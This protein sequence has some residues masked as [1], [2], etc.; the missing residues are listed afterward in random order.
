MGIWLS[1]Q[2]L[3]DELIEIA[4]YKAGVVI[5]EDDVVT[6]VAD[7]S[8]GQ[9]FLADGRVGGRIRP[10]D[11][12]EAV[13]QLLFA[14]GN[15][16]SPTTLPIGIQL[17]HRFKDDPEKFAL[18]QGVQGLFTEVLEPQIDAMIDADAPQGTPIDP[19]PFMLAVVD[20]FGMDGVDIAM[21]M[22]GGAN[23]D[24]HRSPWG[25][26][27]N[28]AWKD[29]VELKSLFESENLETQH[30]RFLDQRFIDFLDQN[31]DRIDQIHWRK[32]EGLTGEW[33]EREGYRVEMGPGRG[34][35]GVDM[36]VF[37]RDAAADAA[38]LIIVQCKRQKA[39]IDMVL[40][41]SVYADVQ[42]ENAESGLIVTTS[43]FSPGADRIK[44]ARTYKVDA[45]DR[46]QLREWIAK[47]RSGA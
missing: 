9:D 25:S 8:I 33:F 7:T 23:N 40:V 21:E 26:V 35:E 16:P 47:M 39:K 11:V 5:T 30:G 22:M 3:V 29:E 15:I 20:K 45:A 37:P 14:L 41:K 38:P 32:F 43:T 31:F 4:G 18:F 19:E 42:W 17:Y 12:E 2:S 1:R 13:A 44:T 36:R 46:P 34:D 27:R 24:M 28:V 6:M 10:E